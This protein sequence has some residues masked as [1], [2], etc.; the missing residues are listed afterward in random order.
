VSERRA[1]PSLAIAALASAAAAPGLGNHF[2]YDDDTIIVNNPLVHSLAG[3][4]RAFGSSYWPATMGGALYRPLPVALFALQWSL[5]HGAPIVFHATSL[6]LYVLVCVLALGLARRVMPEP[7]AFVAAALFAVHPVH[8]EVVANVVG[9]S[10]LLVTAVV[11]IAVTRYLDGR[12]AVAPLCAL[13]A[14]GL[15][16]KE[17]AAVLPALLLVAELTVIDDP[18]PWR[19]R[20]MAARPVATA[21]GLTLVSYIAVRMLVLGPSIGESSLIPLV[22]APWSTRWWTTLGIVPEW[23][24]LLVWPAHLVATYAPPEVAIRTAADGQALAGLTIVVAL[25]AA[26][27]M[28]RRRLPVPVFGVLWAMIALLPVSNLAVP[29]GV[30]LAERSLFLPS[31]GAMLVVGVLAPVRLAWP[32]AVATGL[33]V[34]AGLV[35]SALR[36]PV[37]RD[38][39]T[40]W[41]VSAAESPRNYFTHYQYGTELFRDGRADAGEQQ[42]RTAIALE[43]NDPRLYASLGWRL[44]TANRCETAEPLFRQALALWPTS[45]E[46]RAGLV[47]CLMRDGDYAGARSLAVVAVAHGGHQAFFV[48]AIAAAD[49]A[50]RIVR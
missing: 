45:Y 13:Y 19:A 10:E 14:L 34:T 15:L 7:W 22:R 35:R 20:L 36:A 49:S 11:L 44:T 16:T 1:W 50:Q 47:T 2:A 41:A 33:I 5:G 38:D 3:V 27:V 9:Q 18:R 24:R 12:R 43:P 8:V 37:W 39:A 40:L 21:L 30:L 25:L 46:A 6:V 42:L 28:A 26:C 29:S 31:V 4:V 17:H 23:I 48:H 32:V